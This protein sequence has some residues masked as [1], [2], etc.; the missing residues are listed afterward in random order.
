MYVE[1]MLSLF[2][3]F[4]FGQADFGLNHIPSN[5]KL[6]LK[7]EKIFLSINTFDLLMLILY[8]ILVYVRI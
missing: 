4:V 5:F 6:Q 7:M 2:E 1:Q 3:C 8:K